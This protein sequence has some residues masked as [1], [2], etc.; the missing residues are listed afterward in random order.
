MVSSRW[1]TGP[2]YWGQSFI[3]P[4]AVYGTGCAN[5]VGLEKS[6]RKAVDELDMDSE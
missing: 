3:I 2:I 1:A 4:F 5:C 6:V